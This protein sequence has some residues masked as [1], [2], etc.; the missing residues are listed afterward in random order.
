[1]IELYRRFVEHALNGFGPGLLLIGLALVGLVPLHIYELRLARQVGEHAASG[2]VSLFATVWVALLL[3][4]AVY[5]ARG[6]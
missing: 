1:M 4:M 5:C 6:A 3:V 2:R